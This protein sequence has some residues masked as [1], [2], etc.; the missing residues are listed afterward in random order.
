MFCTD[1]LT[2]VGA[3]DLSLVVDTIRS[4]CPLSRVEME[5]RFRKVERGKKVQRGWVDGAFILRIA[6]M[7]RMRTIRDL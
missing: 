4:W 2:Y 7:G 1:G 6:D 5:L 3:S